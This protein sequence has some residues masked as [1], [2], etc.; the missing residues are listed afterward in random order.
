MSALSPTTR[1]VL[2]AMCDGNAQTL[3]V[4][5]HACLEVRD[6]LDALKARLAAA[7]AAAATAKVAAGL[8]RDR[9]EKAEAR[10]EVAVA[11]LVD[12]KEYVEHCGAEGLLD[13]I[14]ALLKEVP[15]GQ[16]G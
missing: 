6:V 15:H 14:A 1:V 10:A 13:R 16:Q 8:M 3:A 7:E 12:A 5:R 9:A 11:L 2:D 4:M